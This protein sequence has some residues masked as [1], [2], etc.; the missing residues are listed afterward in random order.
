[1]QKG[2]VR[3]RRAVPLSEY[4]KQ[5]R[6]KQE[7]KAQ[8]HLR[9][10][11]LKHY[12]KAAL[13]QSGKANAKEQLLARLETRLDS[14]V[15]RM[16]LADTRRQARQLVSHGHM[17]V[18]GRRTRIPSY[19]VEPGDVVGVRTQSQAHTF[20]ANRKLTLKKYEAPSWLQ[21]D[22]DRMEAEVKSIPSM[23]EIG[24]TLRIPLVFEFY[25]R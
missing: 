10:R 23:E 15:F 17:L 19:R 6:E 14:V 11:Q 21:L 18:N 9:E 4:G 22:R 12:V 24:A 3:K 5:L 16:G 7:L 2:V 1:M 8:Y 25:S 20:F 13:A